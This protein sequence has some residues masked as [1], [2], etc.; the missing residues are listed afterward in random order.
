MMTDFQTSASYFAACVRA[1]KQLGQFDAVILALQNAP[2]HAAAASNTRGELWIELKNPYSRRWWEA[3]EAKDVVRAIATV[4][5]KALVRNVGRIAVLES[6]SAILRPFVSVVLAVS[7]PSPAS[8]FSRFPQL[9]ETSVRHVKFEW[10][11]VGPKAGVLVVVYPSVVPP[12]FA[13]LWLGAVDY[14]YELTKAR[15]QA[16]RSSHFGGRLQFELSWT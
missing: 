12:E 5:G 10:A 15:G 11:A 2:R 1:L 6:M 3:D 8:L 16:S 9:C 7:G 13:E 14:V 4:G